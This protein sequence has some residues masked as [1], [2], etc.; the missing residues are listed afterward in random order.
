MKNDKAKTAMHAYFIVFFILSLISFNFSIIL[1][2]VQAALV[3]LLYAYYLYREHKHNKEVTTFLADVDFSTDISTKSNIEDFP[4]AILI[5]R[6]NT[7]EMLWYNDAFLKNTGFR[8]DE[9]IEKSIYNILEN[10]DSRWLTD[11]V[12]KCPININ[13]AGKF[14]TI[15][16]SA[17]KGDGDLGLM[18]TL[19]FVDATEHITTQKLY[20]ET[21]PIVSIMVIDNYE[22][23][24]KNQTENERNVIL[25]D[26]STKIDAWI[27]PYDGYLRRYERDRYLFLF[28]DKHLEDM[29]KNKF[30]VLDAVKE[31]KNSEGIVASLSIGIGKDADTLREKNDFARLALDMALSRGGDQAV[32]KNKFNFDFFG[33]SNK[34]VQRRSKVKSRVMANALK[35]L[36]EASSH[37]MIM[38]HKS[39]DLDSLGTAVGV[40]VACRNLGKEH[41]I[42]INKKTTLAADMLKKLELSPEYHDIFITEDEAMFRADRDTVLV[43][44]DTNR[45]EYVESMALL[46]SVN[47]VVIIDHHR[48]A[49]SYIEDVAVA[50][51]EPYAS[52]ASELI[53][54]MLQY[55]IDSTKITKLEAEALLAGI[56]LDTKG[57]TMNAATRTF[58]AAAYLKRAGGDM[59]DVKKL[60]QN[61]F[62]GYM[63]KQKIIVS[64]SLYKGGI[65]IAKSDMEVQR[66]I[67]ASAADE[68]LNISDITGSVVIFRNQGTI[69]LSA[70][71]L[72]DINAQRIMEK[73]GGGG[74]FASA[75]AQLDTDDLDEAE[76][77]LKT[78]IDEYLKQYESEE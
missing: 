25:A 69:S 70:R 71:S 53:T 3:V 61:T 64:S 47:K 30:S 72:G 16:G 68:L 6:I 22:E 62:D 65:A 23:L 5:A 41:Y 77:L 20:K 43:V 56:Y 59:T 21:R 27:K 28:D 34:E 63:H 31:I 48:R 75:G 52:S 57:F 26:I 1:G 60:F 35:R 10:F 39:S 18:M 67:A 78:A 14:F 33:G 44:V 54:E 45:P 55:L 73:L 19:V 7:G 9:I 12:E 32:I 74:N 50:V 76:S 49:A 8:H 11:G 15:Y 66:D 37:V 13:I 17:A 2:A 4:L 40:A 36:I 46:D 24:L 58:E 51:H 38:G 29:E 42:V